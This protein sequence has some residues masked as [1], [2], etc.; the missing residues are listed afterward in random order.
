MSGILLICSGCERH[1]KNGDCICPFCGTK[2]AC[3]AGP[4]A[5][6]PQGISRAALL[7]LGAAG[8]LSTAMSGCFSQALYGAPVVTGGGGYGGEDQ[9]TSATGQGG[10]Q[11][12]SATG[13]GGG[14]TASTT[15]QGGAGGEVPDAGKD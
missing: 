6:V 4:G 3:V 1:V 15:G 12:A 7:A 14:Q 5:K 9:T 8:A 13:Q 10:G 11:T 2:V